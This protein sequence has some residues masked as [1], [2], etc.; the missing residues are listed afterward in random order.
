M[1]EEFLGIIKDTG[2]ILNVFYEPTDNT[3]DEWQ[4]SAS[5]TT[6]TQAAYNVTDRE[7]LFKGDFIM[8]DV[9]NPRNISGMYFKRLVVPEKNYMFIT[10][11][12]TDVSSKYRYIYAVQTNEF[13]DLC[14]QMEYTDENLNS[15]VIFVPYATN[16]KAYFTTVPRTQKSTQDGTLDQAIYTCMIPAKY[17]IAPEMRIRKNNFIVSQ[18]I[19]NG[20]V[21]YTREFKKVNYKVESVDTSLVVYDE[22]SDTF[23][24]VLSVQLSEDLR[25]DVANIEDIPVIPDLHPDPDEL[26]PDMGVKP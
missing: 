15:T 17:R 1:H 25:A 24:G 4:T 26:D 6:A 2:E 10:A 21:I 14:E 13:I 11:I 23:T 9:E 22:F 7:F 16:V 8:P 12:E 5:I 20:K 19:V 3:I 18:K